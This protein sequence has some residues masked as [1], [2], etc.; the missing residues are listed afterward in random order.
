MDFCSK[1]HD[2]GYF[3]MYPYL[4]MNEYIKEGFNIFVDLTYMNETYTDKTPLK[5]YTNLLD[6]QIYIKYPIKDRKTPDNI[7]EFKQFIIKLKELLMNN[8]IFI[9][10]RGGSGR[11]GL[12]VACL[13]LELYNYSPSEALK[14]TN[15]YHS[16]R[17]IMSDKQRKWGSPQTKSQKMFVYNY[18]KFLST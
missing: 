4:Y 7:K 16:D 9:H 2:N 6:N 10:C 15:K 18:S 1:F 5:S 3:G 14:L 13:L 12:V 11:S 8:K 17:K